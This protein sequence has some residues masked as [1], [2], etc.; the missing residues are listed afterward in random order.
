MDVEV[1]LVDEPGLDGRRGDRR[2]APQE[3][4]AALLSLQV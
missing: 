4:V 3:D 2:S 1:K